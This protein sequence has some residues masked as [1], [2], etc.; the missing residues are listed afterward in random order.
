M[1]FFFQRDAD[2]SVVLKR[3][4]VYQPLPDVHNYYGV[5]TITHHMQPTSDNASYTANE[6]TSKIPTKVNVDSC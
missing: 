2:S 3:M 6:I 5:W 1:T 4:L